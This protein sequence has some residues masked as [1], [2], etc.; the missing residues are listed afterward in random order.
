M[1]APTSTGRK[2]RPS[3]LRI[4]V[5]M[6]QDGDEDDD[7]DSLP[8]PKASQQTFQFPPP[9]ASTSTSPPV[10]IKIEPDTM[11]TADAL[12][13]ALPSVSFKGP[14][15]PQMSKTAAAKAALKKYPTKLERPKEVPFSEGCLASID[16]RLSGVPIDL[17]QSILREQQ[18]KYW[19][20]VKECKVVNKHK[21]PVRGTL[22]AV[23]MQMLDPTAEPPSHAFQIINRKLLQLPQQKWPVNQSATTIAV[24][25]LFLASRCAKMF[26][27]PTS[28]ATKPNAKGVVTLGVVVVPVPHIQA[29]I[30][31]VQYIYQSDVAT[32]LG[33]LLPPSA[34]TALISIRA[35]T[36]RSFGKQP[37][38]ANPSSVRF[39]IPTLGKAAAKDGARGI[40]T[41]V[42]MLHGLR[43]AAISLGVYD[44]PL[45]AVMDVAWDILTGAIAQIIIEET[46]PAGQEKLKKQKEKPRRRRRP[47]PKPRLSR[48]RRR[49]RLQGQPRG[50]HL[51]RL[52]LLPRKVHRGRRLGGPRSRLQV[53]PPERVGQQYQRLGKRPIKT[54]SAEEVAAKMAAKMAAKV[55]AKVAAAPSTAAAASVIRAR[56]P[57]PSGSSTLPPLH[58]TLDAQT[59]ASLLPAY[60]L[61]PP[62]PPGSID[63]AELTLPSTSQTPSS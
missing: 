28:V 26:S 34:R 52:P 38:N 17:A 50:E 23:D 6:D 53:H 41:H 4:C 19:K 7:E 62:A 35:A 29:F 14:S 21:D 54:V 9:I 44:P 24:H 5:P 30:L 20:T 42:E 59:A 18:D 27:L 45:Y 60:L 43:S 49:A 46:S 3:P 37:E 8:T 55:A 32:V 39:S 31:L 56:T 1:S 11:S 51:L 12:A 16:A 61:W 13:A 47:R 10:A 57:T 36:A 2:T 48:K 25:H 15:A 58:I 33:A 22:V 40:L 63:P